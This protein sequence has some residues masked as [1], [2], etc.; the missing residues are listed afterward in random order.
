MI[1]ADTN[2]LST[3]ARV[4]ALDLLFDLFSHDEIGRRCPTNRH[5]THGRNIR[6]FCRASRRG[7]TRPRTSDR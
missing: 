6:A 3:F 1:L 2:I 4:E 5:A 7:D